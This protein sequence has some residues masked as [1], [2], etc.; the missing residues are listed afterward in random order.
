MLGSY[1][2]HDQHEIKFSYTA[3]QGTAT[4][5]T[6]YFKIVPVNNNVA[7]VQFHQDNQF[8][9]H[10]AVPLG[11]AMRDATEDVAFDAFM[12]S[13]FI[14]WASDSLELQYEGACILRLSNEKLQSLRATHY[15]VKRL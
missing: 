13:F 1:Y 11:F 14:G 6:F 7:A 12:N 10:I 2:Y 15:G 9:S 4:P 3:G 8:D 5:H